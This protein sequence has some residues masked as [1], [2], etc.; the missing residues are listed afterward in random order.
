MGNGSRYI[1]LI[2][3]DAFFSFVLVTG[4]SSKL[5]WFIIVALSSVCI[6]MQVK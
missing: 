6:E 1:Y 5:L 4:N 3:Q 2:I